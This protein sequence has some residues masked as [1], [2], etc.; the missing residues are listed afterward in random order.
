LLVTPFLTSIPVFLNLRYYPAN[1]F[2]V[3]SPQLYENYQLQ[4]GEG[5][6][7]LFVYIWLLGDVFNLA[8]A[9]LGK[10][11]PT[12]IILGAYVSAPSPY[13]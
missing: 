7:V 6:S 3:Y 9:V 11:I 4:S 13:G 1:R 8:G 2:V 10:L 5:V 12:I